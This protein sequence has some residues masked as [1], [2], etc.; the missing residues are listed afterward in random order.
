VQEDRAWEEV[1]H[2]RGDSVRKDAGPLNNRGDN[3]RKGADLLNSRGDS[4]RKDAGLL[5]IGVTVSGKM[6]IL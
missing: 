3:V 2:N 4:V 5:T 6:L 1:W